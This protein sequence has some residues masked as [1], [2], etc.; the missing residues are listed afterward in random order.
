MVNNSP[1][2]IF[3][4]NTTDELLGMLINQYT[5]LVIPILL[6]LIGYVASRFNFSER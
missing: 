3:I 1:T 5:M 6:F 2:T 4:S